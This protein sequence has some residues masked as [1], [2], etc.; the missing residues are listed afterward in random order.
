MKNPL[1]LSFVF[2][3]GLTLCTG[4]ISYFNLVPPGFIPVLL[5]GIAF[6]K[7]CLVAFEFME[8]KKAHVFWKV[9]TVIIGL[10]LAAGIAF[11]S[12]G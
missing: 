11:F 7:F 10:I 5:M 2:L 12:F 6:I 1:L 8:L 3:V 9:A 4:L